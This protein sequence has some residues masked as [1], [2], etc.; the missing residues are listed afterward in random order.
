MKQ[1]QVTF[2]LMLMSIVFTSVLNVK[3]QKAPS[4]DDYND[5]ML[6]Y[7]QQNHNEYPV[8]DNFYPEISGTD[9]AKT[10]IAI[11]K[12]FNAW[13]ARSDFETSEE[14]ET[15]LRD[16]SIAKFDE[17]CIKYVRYTVRDKT[18]A[19]I[20]P[21]C[22]GVDPVG[23]HFRQSFEESQRIERTVFC[24]VSG[25]RGKYLLLGRWGDG[26]KVTI[27]KA[28]TVKKFGFKG[29]LISYDPESKTVWF[30]DEDFQPYAI[31]MPIVDNIE[32]VTFAEEI[33]L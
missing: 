23:G 22:R 26:R 27:I 8:T 16:N 32:N 9:Y 11:K 18:W 29:C 10:K 25:K 6:D 2:V 13:Q 31:V 24:T 4:I 20:L 7:L 21:G 5:D 1:K 30:S 12:A 19:L 14:Y 17:L 33:K 15:R 28:S 3:A